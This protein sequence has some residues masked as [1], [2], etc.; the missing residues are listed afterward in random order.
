MRLAAWRR[1]RVYT[2]QL[3]TEDR[4][5]TGTELAAIRTRHVSTR[6]AS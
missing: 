6:A 3:P 2:I 5:L 4:F 1:S